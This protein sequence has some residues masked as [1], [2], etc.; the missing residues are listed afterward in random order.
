MLVH[1]NRNQETER[2]WEILLLVAENVYHFYP[3]ILSDV[4]QYSD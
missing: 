2:K 3:V 4:F 1:V